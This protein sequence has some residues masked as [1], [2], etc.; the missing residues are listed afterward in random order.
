MFSLA[1][2]R[3]PSAPTQAPQLLTTAFRSRFVRHPSVPSWLWIDFSVPA[4]P[5][6]LP[7]TTARRSAEH[8]VKQPLREMGLLC[9]AKT[10][11]FRRIND[12]ERTCPARLSL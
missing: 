8:T 12:L 5:A 11:H 4:A 1:R 10:L 2:H 3:V 9:L 6:I 7:E